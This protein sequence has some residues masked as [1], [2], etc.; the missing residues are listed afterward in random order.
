MNFNLLNFF[1]FLIKLLYCELVYFNRFII[2]TKNIFLKFRYKKELKLNKILSNFL[3]N[4]FFFKKNYF[5]LL[6]Y[7][8]FLYKKRFN[9][10]I[11]NLKIFKNFL[12]FL[13]FINNSFLLLILNIFNILKLYKKKI[14]ILKIIK[15]FKG[16]FFS[17]FYRK[18]KIIK[19]PIVKFW[20]KLNYFIINN[21]FK[22]FNFKNSFYN[23]YIIKKYF[24][25]YYNIRNIKKY[26]S[27]K[28]LLKK[29]FFFRTRNF[30][31]FFELRISNIIKKL[32][33]LKKDFI[34]LKYNNFFIFN[35]NTLI[36]LKNKNYLIRLKDLIV[37]N[38]K[39][40]KLNKFYYYYYNS[41]LEVN[42][43]IKSFYLSKFPSLNDLSKK[44]SLK[45]FNYNF[46]SSLLN[47]RK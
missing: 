14:K 18:S 15:N 34:Y 10:N 8:L 25:S 23:S 1:F 46:Y 28:I 13:I 43:S 17:K 24:L 30:F 40:Y 12:K 19:F 2:I 6:N 5:F 45:I 20:N 47:I 7:Y 39:Y 4:N 3:I 33:F 32:G 11:I 31:Y 35:K 44:W 38:Y 42:Y 21:N 22:L 27:L 37:L 29:K 16:K 9:L 36:L 26:K 41:F